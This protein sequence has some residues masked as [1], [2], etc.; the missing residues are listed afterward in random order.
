M[1]LILAM[2]VAGTMLAGC[3]ANV[4]DAGPGWSKELWRDL[5]RASPGGD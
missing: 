3:G 1:K 4:T 2:I 5:D